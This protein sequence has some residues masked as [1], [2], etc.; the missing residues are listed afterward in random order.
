MQEIAT[1]AHNAVRQI[2]LEAKEMAE[3]Q[4]LSLKHIEEAAVA[5]RMKVINV[6]LCELKMNLV[7]CSQVRD[8]S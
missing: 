8:Y 1:L 5:A 2:H 7:K 4:S 6:S 3:D